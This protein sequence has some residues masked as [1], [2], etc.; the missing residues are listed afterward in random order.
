MSPLPPMESHHIPVD[1]A[2]WSDAGRGRP[3]LLNGSAVP[4]VTLRNESVLEGGPVEFGN[5]VVS[6]LYLLSN[7]RIN[8][9]WNEVYLMN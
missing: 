7:K 9:Y 3:P 4:V 1:P 5:K 8:K 2:V 6:F